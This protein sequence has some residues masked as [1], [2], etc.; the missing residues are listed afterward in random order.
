MRII[1]T[2]I[3]KN[4][5]KTLLMDEHILKDS[6]ILKLNILG[7]DNQ[8]S[9][10]PLTDEESDDTNDDIL[11]VDLLKKPGTTTPQKN[12]DLTGDDF[13]PNHPKRPRVVAQK[14]K[15]TVISVDDDEPSR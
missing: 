8:P 3:L 11:Q 7:Y 6:D 9:F 10:D 4:S 1:A 14:C 12:R 2:K 15:A 5:R 13:L